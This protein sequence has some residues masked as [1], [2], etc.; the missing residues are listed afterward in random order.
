AVEAAGGPSLA[1]A[2]R[3]DPPG[4]GGVARARFHDCADHPFEPEAVASGEGG[5]PAGQG[6]EREQL[7]LGRREEP[8]VRAEHDA[9]QGRPR[10]RRR[11]EEDRTLTPCPPLPPALTPARERGSFPL[12]DN[13]TEQLGDVLRAGRG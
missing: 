1:L 2:G 5:T 10:A 11:E 6:L 8:R 3:D 12:L 4:L 7:Q 9:Q 13:Q